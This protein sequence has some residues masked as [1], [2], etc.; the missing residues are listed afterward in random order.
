MNN[1]T[2][3]TINEQDAQTALTD[4]LADLLHIHE[5]NE[6]AVEDLCRERMDMARIHYTD[7]R[8][9]IDGTVIAIERA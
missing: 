1:M 9:G 6:T 5:G 8:D 2:V 4:A 3:K 7:E